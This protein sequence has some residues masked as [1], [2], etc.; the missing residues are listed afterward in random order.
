M[1]KVIVVTSNI[2]PYRLRWCEE[3]ARFYDVTI[4]YTK[5]HDYERDDRWLQKGSAVCEVIKLKNDRDVFDPIC[6]DVIG[7]LKKNKDACVIFDGYGPKTNLLGLLYCKLSHRANFVNVDGYPYASGKALDLVK[8]F[9]ISRLCHSFFCSSE[10]TKKHLVSYGADPERVFVHNFSSIRKAEIIDKLPSAGQKR[11]LRKELGIETEK[12]IVLGV[13]RF[14]PLKRFE[15]LITAVRNCESDC[16]LYLLG[17]QPTEDYLKVADNDPR[18]RFI[19]FVL[20]EDVLKYYQACDLFVLPSETDV[21]GLV[22]NE[23]M[24]NGL[25]V[26][27]SDRVVAAL[28]LIQDNG[29]IFKV[30]DTKELQRDIDLCL[31]DANQEKMAQRSLEIIQDYTIEGMVKRQKPQIDK[32]LGICDK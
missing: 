13:G 12:K 5:D 19:D 30:Y 31:Q 10:A 26:I 14:L 16:I 29:F 11:Q 20:P 2:A 24:A 27:A 32:Y 4:V 17:G 6:F 21:W 18:I 28:S 23:A 3:L 9:V 1:A 25:P 15:D 8:R 7:L 22:L